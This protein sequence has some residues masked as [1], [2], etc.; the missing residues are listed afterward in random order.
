MSCE[1][2]DMVIDAIR[3]WIEDKTLVVIGGEVL[4]PNGKLYMCNNNDM[5]ELYNVT[6]GWVREKAGV[7]NG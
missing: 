2:K 5:I 1:I 4:A 6:L 3:D 7:K